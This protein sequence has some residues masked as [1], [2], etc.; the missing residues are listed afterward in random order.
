[1]ALAACLMGVG[2]S[3]LQRAGWARQA[4]AIFGFLGGSWRC[5]APGRCC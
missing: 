5:S 3:L 2:E 1:M 4:G